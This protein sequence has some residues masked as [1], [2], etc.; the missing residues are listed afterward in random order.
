MLALVFEAYGALCL[1]ALVAFLVLAAMA[2]LRPDLDEAEFD[3]ADLGKL[4]SSE[5]SGDVLS[6]EPPIIEE[7]SRPPP[8]PRIEKSKRSTRRRSHLFHTTNPRTI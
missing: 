8:K 3:L 4:V 1:F 6:I 7:P 5:G 2:K